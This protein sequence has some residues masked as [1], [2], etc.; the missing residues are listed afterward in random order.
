[1][2]NLKIRTIITDHQD[3]FDSLVNE[4]GERSSIVVVATQTHFQITNS[5]YRLVAVIY[6]REKT[7]Q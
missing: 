7:Q 2:P 1:M 4:F 3:T 6:Y 5:G